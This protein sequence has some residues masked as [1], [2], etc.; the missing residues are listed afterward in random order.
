MARA[1]IAFRSRG[2]VDYIID[3]ETGL[4]V[5]PGNI[6]EMR[7]AIQFLL[8]NPEE[9]KRMGENARQRVLDELNLETYV[10]GIADVLIQK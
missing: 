9:A 2:I 8:A 7:D 4:L 10:K 6:Q 3:G 1:V 5:E